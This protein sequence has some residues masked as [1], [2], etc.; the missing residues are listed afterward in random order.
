MK[1][2]PRDTALPSC[3]DL[4]ASMPRHPRSFVACAAMLLAATAGFAQTYADPYTIT[5]LA[6]LAGV[7]GSSDGTGTSA[8]FNF[9]SQVAVDANGNAYVTDRS[10]HTIRKVTPAGVTTTIAGIVGSGGVNFAANGTSAQLF[11]P[12][13]IALDTSGNLYFADDDGMIILKMNPAGDVSRLA[14]FGVATPITIDGTGTGARFNHAYGITVD[15]SGNVY[16]A[17]FGG[18]VVRK[19]TPGGTV[20]TLAGSPATAGYADGTGT[21]ARFNSMLGIVV[22]S[23]GNLFVTDSVNRVI[24]KITPA[25]VVTTF[26]GTPG[27]VGFVDGPGATAKFAR[28]AGIAIDAWDYLYVTDADNGAVRRISPS[29]VVETLAG[30]GALATVTNGTGPAAR[31]YYP[32][33]IAVDPLRNIYVVEVEAHVLRKGSPAPSRLSALSVRSTAGSGDATLIMGMVIGGSGSKSVV[34]RGVGPTLALQGVT[35]PLADPQLRLFSGSTQIQ[36]NDDW[37]GTTALTTAFAQVGLAPLPATSRDSALLSTVAPGVYTAWVSSTG[38][39]G[40]AL[41]EVYDTGGLS[42]SNRLSALSVRSTVGTGADVLIVGLVINGSAPRTMLIRGLG[43]ALTAQG[44]GG[45]MTDPQLGIYSGATLTNSN[46]N[47]GGGATL[48]AAFA[49]AGL[50]ALPATSKDAA[51]LVTLLPGVYTVQLSGVNNTTGV[52]LIEMYE[53]P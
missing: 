46:D 41:M 18:H 26:A 24:R 37:G 32:A 28:P 2:T 49:A 33:G 11:H 13:G 44:V 25:G 48:T 14:G 52:G 16:T 50:P 23:S 42:D 38:P 8:R 22:D 19:I 45:V 6:G 53:V 34:I 3:V 43:P 27:V 10:N 17:E 20:T 12:E 30:A 21:S 29:G 5:S 7:T 31:F 35:N 36:S 40:I 4:T 47:W 9:P 39:S 15:P 51:I 1:I